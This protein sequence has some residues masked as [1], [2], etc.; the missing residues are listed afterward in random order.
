MPVYNP[1]AQPVYNP[2]AQPAY[3][4]PAQ[5]QYNPP[6]QPVSAPKQPQKINS[7][8][9]KKDSNYYKQVGQAK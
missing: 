4:P 1:P 2:P 8:S 5:P 3:N 9:I 7:G 6:A